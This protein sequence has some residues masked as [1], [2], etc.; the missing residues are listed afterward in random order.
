MKNG[1]DH[2]SARRSLLARSR[3]L[4]R[5]R[6]SALERE[7][8][9]LSTQEPDW[10]DVASNRSSAMV[11]ERLGETELVQLR[12]VHDALVRLDQGTYGLCVVCGGPIA[13]KRLRLIPEVDR[14]TDCTNHN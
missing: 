10:Q 9:L 3:D 13:R 5:L 7:H 8:E 4:Q 11:L 2:Q 6:D 14:C 12:R 1:S